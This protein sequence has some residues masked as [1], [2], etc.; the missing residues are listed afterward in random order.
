MQRIPLWSNITKNAPWIF[1]STGVYF[2]GLQF[3]EEVGTLLVVEGASMQPTLNPVADD[4][5]NEDHA[6]V[7]ILQKWHYLPRRGDVVCMNVPR[8]SGA[9]VKRIV[10]LPGDLV[11]PR[12]PSPLRQSPLQVPYGHVWV[13]GDNASNSLDSNAYGPVPVGMLIGRV[14]HVVFRKSESGDHP[15]LTPIESKV[16]EPARIIARPP[17]VPIPKL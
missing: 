8:R 2:L 14:S 3:H 10:G 12:V 6:D 5:Y 7:C 4:D 11:T 9:V 17:N 1:V 13:E 15:L 16:P